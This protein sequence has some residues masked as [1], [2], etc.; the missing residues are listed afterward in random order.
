M[1]AFQSLYL[2]SGANGLSLSPPSQISRFQDGLDSP[3]RLPSPI[4]SFITFPTHLS[5]GMLPLLTS[6]SLMIEE[7][8]IA[9]SLLGKRALKQWS[10]PRLALQAAA[11]STRLHMMIMDELD[12]S[13]NSATFWTDSMTVLQYVTNKN[14]KI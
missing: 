1:K 10:V 7:E 2:R 13:I 8:F 3:C 11:V 9:L 5:M 4:F 12:L 6:D 14:K